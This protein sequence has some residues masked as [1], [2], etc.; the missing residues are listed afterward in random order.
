MSI[1]TNR[2]MSSNQVRNSVQN[3]KMHNLGGKTCFLFA[4]NDRALECYALN[5]R[6]AAS[7]RE[8]FFERFSTRYA[9]GC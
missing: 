7:F 9:G 1:K 6:S 5:P 3:T 8:R 2:Q 4:N